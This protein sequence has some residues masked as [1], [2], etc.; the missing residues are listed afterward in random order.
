MSSITEV[1]GPYLQETFVELY[2][3]GLYTVLFFV[4]LYG[5]VFKRQL[6]KQ[7]VGVFLALIAMYILSTMHIVCRWILMRNAFIDN[8][9][10]STTISLYLLQPPLWL[11]VLAAIVFTVNTLM[12]DCVLI[13]RCWTIWNRN[14]WVVALPI[15]CTLA[16]AGLGFK[17][18]QEQAAYVLNPN[19]DRTKF[20]DFATP[21]FALSLVTTCLAT[22]LIIFRIITMTERTTRKSRGYSRIIEI[23]VESALLYSIAM[24]IFL[25][26]LVTD[27]SNDAYAQA[28][29]GQI[30]GL[31]PTL[32]VARVTFG[33]ARPDETW[34]QP[35]TWF[36]ASSGP[37]PTHPNGS[38][39]LGRVHDI[40]FSTDSDGTKSDRFEK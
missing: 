4:T 13:W 9:D 34:Q 35:T 26:L 22:L 38:V 10:T 8:G 20:I 32:I 27:S 25:P 24:A 16:G 2:M 23:V 11:T 3:N 29:V 17:S 36:H 15:C 31:A 5:M 12:A 1:R 7:N 14:W 40:G 6:H 19:L 30:T 28:V 18:I 33:L 21:Y 39:A 37:P